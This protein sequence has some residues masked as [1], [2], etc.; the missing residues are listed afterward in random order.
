MSN[1]KVREIFMSNFVHDCEIFE[2][3]F[4]NIFLGFWI[5]SSH[6]QHF[7]GLTPST[8]KPSTFPGTFSS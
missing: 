2:C 8:V 7:F 5:H 3:Y 1:S 4:A 6:L